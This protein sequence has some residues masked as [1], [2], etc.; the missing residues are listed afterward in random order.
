MA[1]ITFTQNAWGLT[2]QDVVK[3]FNGAIES[4]FET[5]NEC[6]SRVIQTEMALKE[7]E[8]LSYIGEGALSYIERLPPHRVEVTELSGVSSFQFAFDPDQD[9]TIKV[10]VASK[11]VDEIDL[12]ECFDSCST[13]TETITA[14]Q[15]DDGIWRGFL[16]RVIATDEQVVIS[17][18]VDKTAL[19]LPSL[20]QVLRDG[21]C[22]ILGNALYSS[23]SDSWELVKRYCASYDKALERLESGWIPGEFKALDYIEYTG[24]FCGIKGNRINEIR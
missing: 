4:D 9:Y 23:Q 3:S 20:K 13:S 21:V 10:E 16:D 22:C 2:W 8:I 7:G 14:S 12:L 11:C 19:V 24:S 1:A 5:N 17:Y 18:V 15:G 6:G